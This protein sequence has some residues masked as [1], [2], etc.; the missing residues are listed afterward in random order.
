MSTH[1]SKACCDTPVPTAYPEY[2]PKGSYST[3]ADTKCYVVGPADAKKAVFFVYDIFGFK[4]PT[5]Q[6]ADI[7]ANAGY[8][9]VMPDFF[10]GDY[11]QP[12]WLAQDTEE[13]KQKG[14]A[15]LAKL[16][17]PSP[18]LERLNNVLPQ[19]KE[20]YKSVEKWASI[21]F[22]WGGKIVSI[23]S[24]AG[25]PWSVGVQSSPAMVDPADAKK[26]TIPMMMLASKGESADAVKAFGEALTVPKHVETFGDQEH[27]WMSARANLADEKA[28]KEYERG[29]KQALDFIGS[30]L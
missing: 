6:G 1:Q 19:L 11:C 12:E 9:V 13:R 4:Q 3:V 21:G 29:Y 22:C 18:F 25:T 17:D 23:T 20:Q 15:F 16:Q 7:L 8:L 14:Q 28:K 10:M 26:V 5:L 24:G 27:G 2:D 30:N